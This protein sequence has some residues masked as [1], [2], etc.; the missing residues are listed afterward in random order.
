[1]LLS[2]IP[3]TKCD[4][5]SATCSLIEGSHDHDVPAPN[6]LDV[7][8]RVQ[9]IRGRDDPK[10]IDTRLPMVQIDSLENDSPTNLVSHSSWN[11]R[12]F[13]SLTMYGELSAAHIPEEFALV[14]MRCQREWAFNGAFVSRFIIMFCF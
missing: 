6:V 12:A 10:M 2:S 7:G 8:V 9:D 5:E 4:V 11:R 3:S 14:R 1:V 13:E